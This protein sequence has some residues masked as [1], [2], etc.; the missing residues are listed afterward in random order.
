LAYG[1]PLY[2]S[3]QQKAPKPLPVYGQIEAFELVDQDGRAFSSKLHLRGAVSIFQVLPSDA[4]VAGV[5]E[6]LDTMA[7]FQNRVLG[8]GN[9]M[10]LITFGADPAIDTPERLKA[11]GQSK[12]ARFRQWTFL[13]GPLPR[14]LR[15]LEPVPG[16]F[17]LVD[18]MGAVR[19]LGALKK[20]DKETMNLWIRDLAVLVNSYTADKPE[21]R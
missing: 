4:S 3:F 1:I 2:R 5:G 11:L 15:E 10:R 9:T 19:R 18:Q 12:T 17:Y 13:S 20:T 8:T 7:V 14:G 6:A 21:T 16:V